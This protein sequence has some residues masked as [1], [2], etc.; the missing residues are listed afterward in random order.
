[1]CVRM[2]D[3]G[4][5]L[6]YCEKPAYSGQLLQNCKRGICDY[7]IHITVNKSYEFHQKPN[8]RSESRLKCSYDLPGATHAEPVILSAVFMVV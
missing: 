3:L 5:V 1:M 8:S 7:V 4:T 2:L 6:P